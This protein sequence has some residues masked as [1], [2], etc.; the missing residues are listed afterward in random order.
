[1]PHRNAPVTHPD[2]LKQIRRANNID[3]S[4]VV[5][6]SIAYGDHPQI[7]A[8]GVVMRALADELIAYNFLT[9]TSNGELALNLPMDAPTRENVE[10]HIRRIENHAVR[11]GHIP[12]L[13]GERLYLGDDLHEDQRQHYASYDRNL[14]ILG[15]IVHSVCVI[16]HQ[17][18]GG[19]KG[20]LVLAQRH[21]YIVK[22]KKDSQWDVLAGAIA[23]GDTALLTRIGEGHDEFGLS[24][25]QMRRAVPITT[26]TTN[27]TRENSFSLVREKMQV[28]SLGLSQRE[29]GE[30]TCCE[31]KS[32]QIE[33]RNGRKS[34]QTVRAN[35][36]FKIV[37]PAKVLKRLRIRKNLKNGKALAM[38]AYL[39]HT[40]H[41]AKSDP[42]FAII[43]RG[44][45]HK[46]QP[47][48]R[49]YDSSTAPIRHRRSIARSSAKHGICE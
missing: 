11:R 1:M 21:P 23:I 42:M 32:V 22:A 28:S 34:K 48:F 27:R 6:L 30:L 31:E 10:A 43:Q 20:H 39:L 25:F 38:M 17:S 16:T 13:R 19:N 14:D 4:G 40:G 7:K 8:T 12:G 9:I 49:F 29:I 15:F 41:V 46:P 26:I 37:P 36:A 35:I 5:P 24:D 3:W 47:E 2:L 33:D 45:T 18:N 44:L